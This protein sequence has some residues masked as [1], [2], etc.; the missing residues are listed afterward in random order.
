MTQVVSVVCKYM[1]DT[2][3][4][5][6]RLIQTCFFQTLRPSPLSASG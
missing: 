1:D 4:Q 6:I 5:Y 2:Q 3:F